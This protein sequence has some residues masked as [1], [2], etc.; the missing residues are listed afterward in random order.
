MVRVVGA[1]SQTDLSS[2]SQNHFSSTHVPATWL[3]V[4]T[5]LVS[6]VLACA[7]AVRQF[8]ASERLETGLWAASLGLGVPLGLLFYRLVSRWKVPPG[9]L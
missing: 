1:R 3:A 7:I 2:A 8:G 9:V 5:T 4:S 6:V